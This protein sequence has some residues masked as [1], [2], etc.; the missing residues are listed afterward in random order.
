MT[1]SHVLSIF[2]TIIPLLL[3]VGIAVGIYYYYFLPLKYR[4]LLAYFGICLF[5][6]VLSRVAGKLFENNLVLLIVFSLLELLF[7][8]VFFRVCYFR[9][10]VLKHTILVIAGGLYMMTEIFLLSKVAAS[11]FQ[12]YAK[13]LSSFLILV[14][15][16]DYLFDVL[17]RKGNVAE[18][19]PELAAFI[20]YF[21][22]NLIFFLPINFLINVS[23][24]LKFYFWCI[25]LVVTVLFYLFL[26]REIWKNGSMQK[27]LQ[28]GLS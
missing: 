1:F 24:E 8:Y 7:F 12:S 18:S 9:R 28:R 16:I 17:R 10:S 26:V 22:V 4:Y 6:D 11:A 21:S 2:T 5:I 27:Q 20:I 14:M 23:S 19:I 3:V 25:N 13:T 15:V